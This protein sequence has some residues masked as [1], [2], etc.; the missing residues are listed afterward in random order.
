MTKQGYPAEIELLAAEINTSFHQRRP[1]NLEW[2]TVSAWMEA[3][4]LQMLIGQIDV[5]EHGLRYLRE[6]FPTVT[7]A[8][9]VGEIFDR[10]PFAG[11]PLPFK[12][13]PA[14]DIQVVPRERAETALLL[15]CGGRGNLGLPLAVTHSWIGRLKAS[16][17]Y[18]RD[19]RHYYFLGG[20]SSLAATRDATIAAL[21]RIIASLG[22][23]RI[24]CYG[25]SA[26]V[27]GAL[28][29]GLDLEA[30]AVLCVG[31]TVNLSPE[32]NAYTLNEQRA[33][34][35]RADLPDAPLDLRRLYAVAPHPPRV[36][37]IYGTD[38][39]DDRIQA[40]YM[41]TLPC[42]TLQA[43]ENFGEHNVIVELIRR[44]QFE[45]ALHWL[46]PDSQTH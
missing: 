25:A 29:Y 43:I 36:R 44:G 27:F 9:R 26:G 8:N 10:L 40:E 21:R 46:V 19:F 42:V 6:R 5:A 22:T 7:F 2:G 23:K 16:L 30:D 31:G 45:T 24:A 20:V 4:N 11:T 38:Y 14:S 39:W 35:L 12:D 32:F 17:I 37:M 3:V 34:K 28:H 33:N 15:F 1:P 41:G 18:L 13:D